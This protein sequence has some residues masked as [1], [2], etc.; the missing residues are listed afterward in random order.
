[1]FC[2]A[3][4]LTVNTAARVLEEGL[5]AIAAGQLEFDLSQLKTVDSAAIATL[6]A[7]Q[8]AS[9][10]GGKHLIFRNFPPNLR[11]LADLYGVSE[12]L[13]TVS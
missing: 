9:A 10:A 4:A 5:S 1:M 12:L 13:P 3:E 2:P 6:L 11:S 7:W 8:R